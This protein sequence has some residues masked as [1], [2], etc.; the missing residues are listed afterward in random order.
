M[1]IL[2]FLAACNLTFAQTPPAQT[3]T[4]PPAQRDSIIVTGVFEP[5]PLEQ[6]DRAVSAIKLGPDQ[7]ALACTV[8][9][10]LMLKALSL[11]KSNYQ[12]TAWLIPWFAWSLM[13]LALSHLLINNLLARKRF[14]AVPW[15]IAIAAGYWITL[16]RFT[17]HSYLTVI[18][19][20][21][22]FS[23]L[24]FLACVVFTIRSPRAGAT[25]R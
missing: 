16:H 18:G 3:P 23:F 22:A 11:G 9:P 13:P 21:G 14:A 20:L 5:I 4:T 19:T 6:A 10:E 24:L 12:Q 15:L 7:K 8:F 17:Y 25:R 1:R 2:L